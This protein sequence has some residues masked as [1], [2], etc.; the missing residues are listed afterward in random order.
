MVIFTRN[1]SR[2]RIKPTISTIPYPCTDSTTEVEAAVTDEMAPVASFF[3]EIPPSSALDNSLL[4]NVFDLDPSDDSYDFQS[5]RRDCFS[6]MG[7]S[8][9]A[10][11]PPSQTEKDDFGSISEI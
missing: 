1:S 5:D 7:G 9:S 4:D 11:L 8:L 6:C 10:A 2:L 3:T